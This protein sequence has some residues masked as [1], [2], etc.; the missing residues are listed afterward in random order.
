M[1]AGDPNDACP[2]RRLGTKVSREL[3]SSDA[4]QMA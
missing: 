3:D 2:V 4:D 1:L